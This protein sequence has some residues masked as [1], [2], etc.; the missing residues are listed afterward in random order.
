M[1]QMK[2]IVSNAVELKTVDF[3]FGRIYNEKDGIDIH[4]SDGSR[5]KISRDNKESV[6]V[7]MA[8]VYEIR[9]DE[10]VFPRIEI[11]YPKKMNKN[12]HGKMN[13]M[14]DEGILGFKVCHNG[15]PVDLDNK[16]E[17]E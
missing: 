6:N 1:N 14:A 12:S 16:G 2:A 17:V 5:I 11:K 7:K 15:S 8:W 4:L 13:I 10:F 9:D 3:E